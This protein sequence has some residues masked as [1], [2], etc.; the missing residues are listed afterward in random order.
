[1]GVLFI[2]FAV[3]MAVGTFVENSYSTATAKVWIYNA[4]WF[5]AIM[6]FFVINFIGNIFRYRL[7]RKEKL[8]TLVFH[9]SFILILIGAFITRY[10]G[11]EGAMPIREGDVS[12]VIFSEQTYL[13]TFIEGEFEGE[14]LRRAVDFPILMAVGASNQESLSSDFKGQPVEFEIVEYIDGAEEGLVE[15]E[16]GKNYLKIVEAG[17]GNRHDHYLEEGEVASIHNVLF[18]YNKYTKGAINII[19]NDEGYFIDS[20]FEGDFMRMADQARG[21]VVKDSLSPLNLRSLYN[22]ANM[23]FVFPDPAIKGKYD[24]IPAKEETPNLQD[25]IVVNVRS[26]GESKQ[27]KLLGGKGRVNDHKKVSVGGLDVLLRYGSK[28]IELPFSIQLNDFIAEKYPGTEANP[29]PSYSAFKSKVEVIDEGTSEPYEIYMNHVL[30]HKGYRFFQSGFDPDEGGTILS[31][32]HD[33]WGTWVTYIGYFLLYLGL[34]LIIFVKESRFG[35]LAKQLEKIRKKKASLAVILALVCLS[36]F[37]QEEA[38]DHNDHDGHNHAVEAFV[39]AEN[40]DPHAGHNHAPGEGHENHT[41]V[42]LTPQ[43]IQRIDSIIK[44]TAVSP[45]HAAKFGELVIQDEG[46]R[47]KPINTYSSELLRKI[48]HKEGYEGLTNDQVLISMLENPALWFNVPLIYVKREND[49][50]HKMIGTSREEQK[51]LSFVQFFDQEANYKLGSYLENAYRAEVKTSIQ[52]DLIATDQKVNLLNRTLRGDLLN[53][54]PIPGDDNNTWVTVQATAENDVFE[55]VDSVYVKQIIPLYFAS[56]RTAK[57]NGDYTQAE[58]LLTSI[59]GFQKKYGADVMPSDQKIQAEIAYNK[60]DVFRKLYRYLMIAGLLM[61]VFVIIKIFKEN[62]AVRYT[63]SAFKWLIVVLFIVHTAGLIARWYISGHAPWSNAY[64]SMLYIAW[65]TLGM[66]L[67]FGR[68]SELTIASTA[69]VSSMILMI[70]HWN[71][72]DPEIANLVPVLDSYWLMIHVSVIVGSYG[73][74]ALGMILG[75]VALLLMMFTTKKNRAKMDLNIKEITI[76]TELAITVGLIMLT[77]G[78]FLGGQWANESWG[79]YWGWDPKETWALITIIVYAFVLHM[80]LIPGL[81]GR[82][83]FNLMAILAF[84]SVLMTYFGVNFYL[85]GL[86]SYAS[87]DQ[88]I[89][90][91]FIGISLAIISVLG[92]LSKRQYNKHLERSVR[93]G[94]PSLNINSE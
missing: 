59:K 45:E 46:G 43:A 74:F 72:L 33:W 42:A 29:Q 8:V 17:D 30:D 24:I 5:E 85:S 64:E 52:K 90:Y 40:Q 16:A 68:K 79:R 21:K 3:A 55:G 13:S 69:F 92:V 26:N 7:L 82:W 58:D 39:P 41:T 44:A 71:W 49:S 70:A 34:I 4:W 84:G 23:Q 22:V 73:P 87:G 56:L 88:I 25:A 47:M 36:A 57:A 10:I 12:N 35:F 27:V 38:Q 18:A 86:H 67:A 11:Y 83:L 89:S 32:N 65:A 6:V 61:F 15:D 1:M 94:S 81:R 93:G 91:K 9:L 2:V 28:E 51:L 54:F 50:I 80:R 62:K 66:G 14:P 53:L 37:A 76:I 75:V 19:I 31:V 48:S 77:I 20:P 63:V 60:Y 78:N